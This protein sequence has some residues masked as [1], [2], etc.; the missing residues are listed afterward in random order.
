MKSTILIVED[1]ASNRRILRNALVDRYEVQEAE[2]GAAG[3][4][5]LKSIRPDLVILD[6]KMPNMDGFQFLQELGKEPEELRS[7]PVLVLTGSTDFDTRIQAL[8]LGAHDFLTKPFEFNELMLRVRNH[9]ELKQYRNQLDELVRERTIELESANTRLKQTQIMILEKLGKAAEYRDDETGQHIQ[10]MALYARVIAETMQLDPEQVELI[11]LAAP[12]HDI[13]KIGIPDGVL[14]KPARL[15]PGEFTI[16]KRHTTI[17]AEILKG[18]SNPLVEMGQTLAMYHHE[19]WD[20]SG[21]PCGL[22]RSEIPLEARIIA[23]ADVFDALSSDRVYRLAWPTE[24]AIEYILKGSENHFDPAVVE[25]FRQSLDKILEIR[26]AHHDQPG[27]RTHLVQIYEEYLKY[28][29]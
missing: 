1:N 2:D 28:R 9:L 19:K 20:G 17:G 29:E 18:T 12:M 23:C 24:R 4:K 21:Y 6:I 25:A 8:N 16:M 11:Y 27:A 14:L 22:K 5:L 13:G 10:R 15:T 26:K 3:L 7:I